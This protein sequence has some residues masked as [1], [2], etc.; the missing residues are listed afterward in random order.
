MSYVKCISGHTSARS[1]QR[2]LERGGRALAT[3]F[4]NIDTPVTGVRDGLEDHGHIDWW[5]DM[6]RTRAVFGNDAI[7]NEHRAHVEVL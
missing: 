4:L 6:D 2:Y 5:R 1:V 7:W 3:D